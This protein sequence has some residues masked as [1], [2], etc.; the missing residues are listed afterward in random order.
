MITT[1]MTIPPPSPT[2][3]TAGPWAVGELY[4]I[5]DPEAAWKVL[6]N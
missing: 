5:A 6:D 4:E 3:Q 1:R 2:T